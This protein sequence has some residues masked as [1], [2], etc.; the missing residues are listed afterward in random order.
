[1]EEEPKVVGVESEAS[2]LKKVALEAVDKIVQ[3][4]KK[5]KEK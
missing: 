3:E 4:N 1:M 2:K 5:K